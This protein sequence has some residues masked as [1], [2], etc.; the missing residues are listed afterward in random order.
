[1]VTLDI[2]RAMALQRRLADEVLKELPYFKPLSDDSIRYVAG[3][4]TAYVKDTAVGVAVLI[5]Y[6]SRNLV[7]YSVVYK[8]PPIPYIPGLLAFREA[9]AYIAAVKKLPKEPDVIFVDGHGLSHPR[10]MGIATHLGLV[11]DKP[12]I[13]VAKKKLYG[14]VVIEN[15]K[16]YVY[17]HG[18]KVGIIITHK[19]KDLYVSIGYKIDLDDALRITVNLLDEHY[20]L[21]LPTALAD[22][23]SKKIA[24]RKGR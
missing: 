2:R 17:A 4:D 13:G 18:H 23:L 16:R 24:R 5:D 20:K 12:T 21:P 7:A 22:M 14:E 15:N 6:D 1:M 19:G 11:L 9:P 3:V 10:A 8:K